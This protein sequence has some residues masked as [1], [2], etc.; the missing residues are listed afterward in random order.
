MEVYVEVGKKRVFAGALGWP[1]WSR[2]GKDEAEALEALYA[3]GRRYGQAIAAAGLGFEPPETAAGFNVV[4]RLKGNAGTDFGAPS[5][6]PT[7]DDRPVSEQ[8]LR[9]LL[10]LLEAA[11]G[12]FDA[13]AAAA[14]G[15]TLTTG[16]RGGGRD[17]E[18]MMGHVL[19]AEL[20]YLRQLGGKVKLEEA[21]GVQENFARLRAAVRE[22]L[23]AAARG[24]V[25]AEGPRGGKR[26]TPRYFVRRAAWH[27]LDHAWEME[28]RTMAEPA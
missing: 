13:A 20:A 16:P 1:G 12:A 8:E 22:T 2:S 15:K 21:A 26:W 25:A 3:Y 5:L 24:E 18:K 9:D 7:E 4:E 27:V 19:E 6:P 17:R 28:D 11:W 23:A 14:E 10:A